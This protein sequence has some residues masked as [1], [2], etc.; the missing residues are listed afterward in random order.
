MN[1]PAR[2][3]TIDLVGSRN[4]LFFF[5]GATA[6]IALVLLAIPP[7][8]KPGIEFTSGT[9][10]LY[11]FKSST[12][13]SAVHAV[14]S[15]LGHPEA[16]IQSTGANEYLIRT[17]TLLVPASSLVEIAPTPAAAPVGP[18]P[19][20]DRG[21]LLI[22][23]PDQFG[24]IPLLQGT[25]TGTC[26]M[27]GDQVGTRP[28]GTRANVIGVFEKCAAS[29]TIYRVM[30]DG[31]VGYILASNT[32]D[33]V[34][35][36]PPAETQVST[37]AGADD[38]R[39]TIEAA[40]REKIGLF[41]VL[42]FAQVS[43]VVSEA[44]VRNAAIAV[45]AASVAIM[46]YIAFAFRSVPKPLLYG[47]CAIVAMLHDV[48]ITL[49]FFS[50]FGKVFDVEVNLMFVTGLLTIIGF[51]VHDTIVVFDRIRENIRQH[52]LLPLAANVNAALLQTIAR[53]FNTSVTVLLTVL[54]LL[55]LGGASIREFL[56]VVLVGIISGTY[57]SVAVASQLLVAYEDGDCGRLWARIRGR[58]TETQPAS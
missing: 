56:L 19:I 34:P 51:S 58:S 4:W 36:G 38:E 20:E 9:T 48:L 8:L 39:A 40:L 2:E 33:F 25:P 50:F 55:L 32:R 42:E 18:A 15:A 53:S 12:T 7:S 45:F 47:S 13:A 22:G 57:S 43:A 3:R 24:E 11:R 23:G 35:S 31:L 16:R 41:S 6:L 30:A 44:A 28:Y 27:L 46:F 14:Y 21:T 54:A 49:G 52:P 1:E 5:S 37:L 26:P 29:A 10:S 17:T